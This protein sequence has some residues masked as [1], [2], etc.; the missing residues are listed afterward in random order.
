MVTDPAIPKFAGE[1]VPS[2]LSRHATNLSSAARDVVAED[3]LER[4]EI[5]LESL[6]AGVVECVT[7]TSRLC[8]EASVKRPGVDLDLALLGT[9]HDSVDPLAQARI[10]LL[11]TEP[12][13]LDAAELRSARG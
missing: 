2:A 4:L 1:R 11:G 3:P 10:H 5:G 9:A 7:D 12:A 8:F 6:G 13:P